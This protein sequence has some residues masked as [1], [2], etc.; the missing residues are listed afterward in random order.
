MK[1]GAISFVIAL[2]AA[3]MASAAVK[4]ATVYD[5][6]TADQFAQIMRS[7]GYSATV[8]TNSDGTKNVQSY[9]SDVAFTAFLQD[10]DANGE[11][12][13]IQF[14]ATVG[15]CSDLPASYERANDWNRENIAQ[16]D[17][18]APGCT[19]YMSLFTIVAGVSSD[20]L[21][22]ALGLW[23]SSM[24]DALPFFGTGV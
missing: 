15:T 2:F 20:D 4:T 13:G 1:L 12:A 19:V 10:C 16:A 21:V 9:D 6:I 5:G 18:G 11:C 8:G 22:A 23:H 7:N 14:H 17:V 3:T 24:R